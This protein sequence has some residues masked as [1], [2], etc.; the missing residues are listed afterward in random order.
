VVTFREPIF[1]PG[2]HAEG[3]AM[4]IPGNH[5][6]LQAYIEKFKIGTLFPFEM[7]NKFIYL[8]GYRRGTTLTY[9]DFDAKLVKKDPELLKLFPGLKDGEKDKT[10]DQLF[11]EAVQP[12]VN[13]RGGVGP[14]YFGPAGGGT[15]SHH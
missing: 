12:V 1:A 14:T 11:F 15:D 6:L 3:G 8:F 5:F 13:G 10:C 4:R 9:D 2:L 7:K